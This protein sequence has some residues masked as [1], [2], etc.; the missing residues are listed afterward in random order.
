[1]LKYLHSFYFN[2][3]EIIWICLKGE[4]IKRADISARNNVATTAGMQMRPAE[5]PSPQNR[6]NL[7]KLRRAGPALEAGVVG[8]IC[9]FLGLNILRTYKKS[10]PFFCVYDSHWIEAIFLPLPHAAE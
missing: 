7:G 6:A 9:T 3:G 1:M 5:D 2:Q 8:F 10:T 4:R